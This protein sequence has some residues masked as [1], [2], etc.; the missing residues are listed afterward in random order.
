M[1]RLL[2]KTGFDKIMRRIM[3]TGGLTE[4]ME[5]DVQRLRD[6]YDEREGILR[7]YGEAYDGEAD[8][9]DWTERAQDGKVDEARDGSAGSDRIGSPEDGRSDTRRTDA[10]GHPLDGDTVITPV[11]DWKSRYENLRRQY[12]DRFFGRESGAEMRAQEE[13]VRKDSDENVTFDDLLYSAE[14][15]DEN[16]RRK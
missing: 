11:E 10:E 3:E 14:G 4:D 12:L 2:S 5:R 15:A 13:D 16:G 9:Y 8:E 1:P 6:E 7:K